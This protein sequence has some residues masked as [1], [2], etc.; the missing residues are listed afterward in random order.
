MEDPREILIGV[1]KFQGK[2]LKEVMEYTGGIEHPADQLDLAEWMLHHK[3]ANRQE[4]LAEKHRL[5]DER[6]KTEK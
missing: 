1:F 3:T 5:M 2:S 6:M 4:I